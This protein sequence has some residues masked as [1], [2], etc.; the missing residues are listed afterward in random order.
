[1]ANRGDHMSTEYQS[2]S[3]A[4]AFL[5]DDPEVKERVDQEIARSTLVTGLIEMRVSKGLTQ[6]D[7]AKT[8]HCDPSKISKLEAGNDLTLKWGDILGYMAAMNMN[9][10]L[11]VDDST[12]PA[13]ERIKQCVFRIRELLDGLVELAKE[14]DGDTSI[15]DKI[16]QFYGEVLFN[17]ALGFGDS[18]G[19]LASVLKI[20][21]AEA[22]QALLPQERAGAGRKKASRDEAPCSA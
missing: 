11:M 16:H 15:T 9:I 19:K 1:M 20:P 6:K 7:V 8:M 13:A 10:S 4:A 22:M 12:L 14:V 21:E 5:A 18:Y 3:D 2:V 17:F